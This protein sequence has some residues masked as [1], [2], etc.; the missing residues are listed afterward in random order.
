MQIIPKSLEKSMN[1]LFDG[2]ENTTTYTGVLF[3]HME[4]TSSPVICI[5]KI[6]LELLSQSTHIFA[7]ST[8]SPKY[9]D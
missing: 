4:E 1:Q 5:C 2:R 7:D 3:C 6:N 9:F 8:F